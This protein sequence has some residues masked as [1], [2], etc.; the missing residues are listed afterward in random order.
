MFTLRSTDLSSV[1]IRIGHVVRDNTHIGFVL[2]TGRRL[3][4][5]YYIH[6]QWMPTC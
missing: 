3:W 1:K 5:K 4:V 6:L 2:V